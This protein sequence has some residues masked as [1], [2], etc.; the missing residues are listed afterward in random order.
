VKVTQI[1]GRHRWQFWFTMTLVLAETGLLLLFPLF[2]GSAIDGALDQQYWGVV[3][4]GLLGGGTLLVGAFRRFFD[5]RFYAKLYQQLGAGLAEDSAHSTSKKSAQLGF[6]TELVEFFENLLPGLINSSIGLVGTVII[7]ATFDLRLL[8]ACLLALFLTFL[9][10]ACSAR[11][12]TRLNE[13]YNHEREKQVDLLTNHQPLLFRHHLQRLM[14]WNIRLSD[15]ETLNFSIVWLLL[16]GFLVGGIL[17][18]V[19]AGIAGY[20]A[21]FS[22]V[23]Y[24][25]QFMETTAELPLYYQQWLRLRVIVKGINQP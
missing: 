16:M 18:V 22:L 25:F 11:R 2:I 4:L 19:Q 21:L 17:Y 12:T 7:I 9:V 1:V 23:L 3:K 5:S 24:L 14:R 10:Y 13:G 6:L 8:L 20:G 15:L